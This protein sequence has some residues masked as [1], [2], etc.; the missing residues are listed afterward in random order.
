MVLWYRGRPG[1]P[2]REVTL[3]GWEVSLHLDEAPAFGDIASALAD[4]ARARGMMAVAGARSREPPYRA[5]SK[6]GN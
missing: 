1:P 2:A 3:S 6:D 4:A 5:P